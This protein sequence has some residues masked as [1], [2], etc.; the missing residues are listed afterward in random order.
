MSSMILSS[1]AYMFSNTIS[2]ADSFSVKILIVLGA[3]KVWTKA[4]SL[5]ILFA[6]G[7]SFGEVASCTE[8][9]VVL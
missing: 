8:K 1:C 3:L 7:F 9:L 2:W 6:K 5:K 4:L